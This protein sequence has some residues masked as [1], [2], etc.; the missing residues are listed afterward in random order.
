MPTCRDG[1]WTR[2][3]TAY[4]FGTPA[5]QGGRLVTLEDVGF[6]RDLDHPAWSAL[7]IVLQDRIVSEL[8]RAARYDLS[9]LADDASRRVLEAARRTGT[10]GLRVEL[11]QPSFS[12]DGV[13]VTEEGLLAVVTAETSVDVTITRSLFPRR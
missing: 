6:A 12:V 7:G 13:A 2:G 8:R 11:S 10:D 1:C 4:L 5:L 3:G 9:P